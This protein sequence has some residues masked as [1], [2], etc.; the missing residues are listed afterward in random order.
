MIKLEFNGWKIEVDIAQT[1]SFYEKYHLITE[2]C[3]CHYCANYLL[4]CD[5]FSLNIM[6]LFQS[7]G[8]DPKKEGEVFQHFQQEDGL[9]FYGGFYH[10]VGN[11][12]ERSIGEGQVIDAIDG[13]LFSFTED[14][15]LVPNKFPTPTIQMEFEMKIPWL[16]KED[17]RK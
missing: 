6:G 10:I 17:Y 4:A 11:I 9:H 2:D 12:L 13:I 7:L 16:L 15:S 3:S 14:C 8:I 5:T 1:K